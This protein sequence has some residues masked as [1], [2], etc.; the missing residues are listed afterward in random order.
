MSFV[1]RI[2]LL[3][4]KAFSTSPVRIF[5]SDMSKLLHTDERFKVQ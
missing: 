5:E 4:A 3:M 1:L 2:I